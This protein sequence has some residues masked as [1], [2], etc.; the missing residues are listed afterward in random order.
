MK[1]KA[2][3]HTKAYQR[4]NIQNTGMPIPEQLDQRSKILKMHKQSKGALF[5]RWPLATCGSSACEMASATCSDDN[6]WGTQH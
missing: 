1:K 3:P 5:N 6:V 4:K 2:R